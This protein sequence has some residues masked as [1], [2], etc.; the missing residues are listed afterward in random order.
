MHRR[1]LVVDAHLRVAGPA[2]IDLVG[3]FLENWTEATGGLPGAAHFADIAEFD[4]GVGLQVTRSTST[5]GPP[6]RP[7][8][9]TRPSPGPSAVCG[10]RPP[11]SLPT[12][13]SRTC[14][15]T[16][17]GGASTSA[18]WSTARGRQGG[19]PPGRAALPAK[20]LGSGRQL[21]TVA[22]AEF[23][24]G[25]PPLS[26]ADLQRKS[27]A[28]DLLD[29]LRRADR[30]LKVMAKTITANTALH[31]AAI[32]LGPRRWEW[33]PTLRPQD[34]RAQDTERS[35]TQPEAPA[36]QRRLSARSVRRRRT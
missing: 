23:L 21:S 1:I 33:T 2:V 29:D 32:V 22:A 14:C 5:R 36:H 6:R 4:G 25:T 7:S 13:T 27:I 30:Q 8:S 9:F 3:A 17:P 15:A 19:G 18:S 11:T 26:P 31:T 10:S 12:G 28:R 35:A 24:A 20:L 16:R 34:R